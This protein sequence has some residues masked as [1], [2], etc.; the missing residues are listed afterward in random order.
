MKESDFYSQQGARTRAPH[1]RYLVSGEL[2]RRD[3]SF[4]LMPS[5][6][7]AAKIGGPIVLTHVYEMSNI[8]RPKISDFKFSI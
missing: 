2:G 3:M 5:T 6:K 7:I 8:F 4:F 1:A